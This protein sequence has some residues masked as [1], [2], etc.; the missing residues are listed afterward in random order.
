MITTNHGK[1]PPDKLRVY[2]FL[3]KVLVRFWFRMGGKPSRESFQETG[4]FEKA[5]EKLSVE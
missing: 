1:I 4:G 2:V 5:G 3:H